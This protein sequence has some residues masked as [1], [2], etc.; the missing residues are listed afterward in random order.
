MCRRSG[1]LHRLVD[2]V[3]LF[4]GAAHTQRPHPAEKPG[5]QH[6]DLKQF[7]LGE[8]H[9]PPP[10][11]RVMTTNTVD[12]G[13]MVRC[14]DAAARPDFLQILPADALHPEPDVEHDH[15]S[16]SKI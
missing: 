9:H 13:N 15:A 5:Q 6:V 8:D 10:Q 7:L 4:A 1:R 14:D 3:Q 12:G 2:H 16:G 11:N